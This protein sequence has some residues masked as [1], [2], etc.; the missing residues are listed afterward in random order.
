MSGR[1]HAR[2]EA[3]GRGPKVRICAMRVARMVT[4][5]S[6]C[7]AGNTRLPGTPSYAHRHI[8][9]KQEY[10][11]RTPLTLGY[12]SPYV[13]FHDKP[14]HPAGAPK[15]PSGSD[16]QLVCG[17][18]ANTADTLRDL[19]SAGYLAAE[20]DPEPSRSRRLRTSAGGASSR[21]INQCL[22]LNLAAR[23]TPTLSVLLVCSRRERNDSSRFF[24]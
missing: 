3:V 2:G 17:A 15:G 8:D 12:R 18:V 7:P 19:T 4:C 13:P 16:R 23:S 10:S 14:L 20:L 6:P 22:Q 9:R 21:D 5:W 24:L 1:E 11:P